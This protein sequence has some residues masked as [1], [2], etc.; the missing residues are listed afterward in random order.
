MASL[1]VIPLAELEAGCYYLGK[2]RCSNIGL[3][4]GEVFVVL[5]EVLVYEGSIKCPKTRLG[6]K[7]EPYYIEG[8]GG[9]FEPY[10][11][12]YGLVKS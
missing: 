8:K 9:S 6:I 2:G 11:K 12:A 3:W 1:Q 7:Y 10:E 5:A 4:N